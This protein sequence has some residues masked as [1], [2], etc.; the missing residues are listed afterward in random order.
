MV[1]D[2]RKRHADGDIPVISPMESP[3]SQTE[4]PAGAAIGQC[5]TCSSAIHSLVPTPKANGFR[6]A[7]CPAIS[8]LS[9]LQ[10][11]AKFN[12]RNPLMV[13]LFSSPNIQVNC[14]Q[15]GCGA[16]KGPASGGSPND[17]AAPTEERLCAI[18]KK[19]DSLSSFLSV[20]GPGH[21][22]TAFGSKSYAAA[23]GKAPEK[24]SF[25]KSLIQAKEKEDAS[26][27]AEDRRRRSLLVCG[28]GS[29]S[30]SRDSIL[31]KLYN[32]FQEMGLPAHAEPHVEP[33]LGRRSKGQPAQPTDFRVTFDSEAPARQALAQSHRLKGSNEFSRV[34]IRPVR[35]R[36]EN[37][38]IFLRH[39]RAQILA[40]E[41]P[42]AAF[43]VSYGK[44]DF[45]ILMLDQNKSLVSDWSD[46][47]WDTWRSEFLKSSADRRW[48]EKIAQVSKDI[49]VYSSPPRLSG[50]SAQQSQSGEDMD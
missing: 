26:R 16:S 4:G 11:P 10:L 17:T 27:A 35:T 49:G 12:S 21:K 28:I 13:T 45:P 37:L 8:C 24:P 47:G 6:C 33:F 46:Q 38:L 2:K 22:P 50:Q 20:P 43:K 15:R 29:P 31:G 32:L 30:D 40:A 42:G 9:C 39:K 14:L 5:V 1:K 19:L 41:N 48:A 25:V 36:E 44:P 23:L 18:E 7:S 3:S 34:F